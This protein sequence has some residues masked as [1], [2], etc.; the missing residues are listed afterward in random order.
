MRSALSAKVEA[1]ELIVVDD[2]KFTEVKTKTMVGVLGNLKVNKALVVT[3][4]YEETVDKS[5]RNIPGVE[6]MVST[7]LNVY[8]I[9]AHDHLVITKDAIGKVEEALA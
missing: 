1:G 3:S 5:A 6:T 7:G 2:F 9:L 4:E 8:D